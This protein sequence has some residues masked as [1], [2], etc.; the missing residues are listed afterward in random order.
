MYFPFR[1]RLSRLNKRILVKHVKSRENRKERGTAHILV[2]F[3]FALFDFRIHHFNDDPGADG[4]SSNERLPLRDAV[5]LVGAFGEFLEDLFLL[6]IQ[7]L[8]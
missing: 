7:P 2:R 1:A 3:L 5:H 6:F 4:E 8:L